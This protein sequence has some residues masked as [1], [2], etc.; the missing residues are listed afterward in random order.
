MKE[1][2]GYLIVA[3]MCVLALSAVMAAGKPAAAAAE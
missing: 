3:L 1:R 2:K